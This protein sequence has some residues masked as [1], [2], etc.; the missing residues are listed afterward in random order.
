MRKDFTGL[1]TSESV[2]EGHPDKVADLIADSILDVIVSKDPHAH[3]AIEVFITKGLVVVGGEVNT[4]ANYDVQSIVRDALQKIGYVNEELGISYQS[5]CVLNCINR[6]SPDI[7]QAV[8]NSLEHRQKEDDSDGL[9]AGDQGL[10]FGFACKETKELMPLPIMMA[11]K[12]VKLAT[13][14]RKE[15]KLPWARPDMKSQVTIEYRDGKP[16][17]VHTIVMAIQ[18]NEDVTWTDIYADTVKNVINPVL[19]EYGF[20]I[21]DVENIYVNSS[22]RFV[23]GGP[24]GDTGLTGRK[25]IVDTYGGY[26]PHGG[27]AISGKDVTKVDRIGQYMARYIA[28]NIVSAGL[29]ERCLV[30]LAYTIGKEYPVSLYVDTQET[31]LVPDTVITEWVN[32][33]FDCRPTSIIERFN[34]RRPIYVDTA[35]YG[36][37]GNNRYPWEIVDMIEEKLLKNKFMDYVEKEKK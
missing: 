35:N 8:R 32:Q 18:H 33:I 9:G 31:G 22:G 26:V 11:H 27:G 28:K 7:N 13:F 34:L 12:L 30:Q 29:A 10:M 36:Q 20:D 1:F 14:L 37:F 24:A 17:R 5:C 4:F 15:G 23:V 2:S 16:V 25:I 3:T 21:N 6:Q 19:I